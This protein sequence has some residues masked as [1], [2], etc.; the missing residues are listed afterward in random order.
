MTLRDD[1]W[2]AEY[3]P[4]AIQVEAGESGTSLTLLRLEDGTYFLEGNEV[5]SGDTVIVDGNEYVL[6]RSGNTWSVEFQTGSVVV[7]LP[8]GGSVTLTKQENGTYTL[9]GTVVRSGSTRTINGVRYRLTLGDDGW[10]ATRRVST[11]ITGGTGGTGGGGTSTRTETDENELDFGEGEFRLCDD[12]STETGDP[13]EGAYLEVGD[14]SENAG[15]AEYS[16][17]ELLGRSGIASVERTYVE[18][19]KEEIEGIVE[20]IRMRVNIYQ[21]FEDEDSNSADE[22]IRTGDG[23]NP[24]LWTQAMAALKDIFGSAY[25][26]SHP[27]GRDN[28]VDFEDVDDV[29][30]DLEEIVDALSSLSAFEDQFE[31]W[32]ADE[33]DAEDYFEAPTSRIKFGS[34]R[35]TRF[36]VYSNKKADANAGAGDWGS[37]AFAYSPLEQPDA[38]DL[39]TRGEAVYRG[40]TVAVDADNTTDPAVYTGTIELN[41]RFSTQRV[42]A[43]ITDLDDDDGDPWT[44]DI[45]D[46]KDVESVLL[47]IAVFDDD[48][49]FSQDGIATVRHPAGIGS[50]ER[51]SASEFEGQFVDGG[52]E[53][54]G[55]WKV[56][57][58]LEGAFGIRRSSSSSA[59]R[60]DCQRPRRG[61]EGIP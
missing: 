53:I 60:P 26:R 52:S 23:T 14:N 38:D 2:T 58:V 51:V 10:T 30:E 35:N 3:I 8:G 7:G 5:Q 9:A 17:Y 47:P 29:I 6:T 21:L 22:H 45:F 15:K 54:L 24:G 48:G 34:T 41:A 46:N 13:K 4:A 18:A 44:H 39:P 28:E 11:P 25:D 42:D 16:L 36:G 27:W 56:G 43:T 19:A 50:D 61:I 31:D 32:F 57:T 55:T 1:E 12:C 20:A 40:D 59:T 37:G 49:E 33:K